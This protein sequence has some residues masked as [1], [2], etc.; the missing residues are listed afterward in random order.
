[1]WFLA[2]LAIIAGKV[3]YDAFDEPSS[4]SSSSSSSSNRAD[5]ENSYK[6]EKKKSIQDDIDMYTKKQIEDI[7]RKYNAEIE[8]SKPVDALPQHI[9]ALFGNINT[10]RQDTNKHIVKILKKDERYDKAISNL[11]IE[12]GE[13]YNLIQIL[14]KEKHDIKK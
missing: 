14:K 10:L 1:M 11:K 4:S 8:I 2:P 5:V 9:G 12:Q 6:Q 3:I 7:K 13:I